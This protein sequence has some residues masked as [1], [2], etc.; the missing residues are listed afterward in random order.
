MLYIIQ[1]DKVR[2]RT[3]KSAHFYSGELCTNKQDQS[4]MLAEAWITIR[5]EGFSVVI[6]D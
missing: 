2:V 5:S 4:Q 3:F 1:N 6:S